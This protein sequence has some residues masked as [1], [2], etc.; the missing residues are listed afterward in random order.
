MDT[1][2]QDLRYAFRVLIKKPGFLAVAVIAL[3]LGIGANSAIFSV[4]NSVLL[5]SLPYKDADRLVFI[6][7][8]YPKLNLLQASVSAPSYV[9]YRDK[10]ESFEQV[11]AGTGWQ[12]NLTGITEPERLR[13][14]TVTANF[15]PAVGVEPIRGRVFS[16]EEDRPGNDKVVLISH[17]LWQRRFGGREDILNQT[18][19]LDDQSHTIIGILP[20]QFQ[21]WGGDVDAVKPIAFTPEQVA[22]TNGVEYLVVIAKLKQG[23]SFEQA[24]TEM[25]TVADRLRA[26]FYGEG[27]S[28][29][30][31]TNPLPEELLGDYRLML[32]IPFGF[33]GCVLLI[34]CANVANLMLARATSRQREIAIRTALGA[35]RRRVVRQL[36]TESVLLSLFGGALGIA[37]AFVAI[38]LLV[39]GIPAEVAERLIG[40]KQVGLNAEVLVFTIGVSLLTGIV[41]GIVPAIQASRPDLNESLKEGGRSGSEGGHRNRIRSALVVF[42]VAIALVLLVGAGLLI[43]SFIKLQEVSPGFN[44]EGVLTMQM[45]LPRSKYNKPEEM[46]AFYDRALEKISAT[47][48]VEHAAFGTNLPMSNNNSSASFTIEGLQVPQGEANPHGDNH[49]VTSDY[50]NTMQIPLIEGRYFTEQDTKDSL[51]VAIIDKV[52]ADKYFPG[53]SAVGKRMAVFFESQDNN[54][55]W[56]EIVGVV[57]NVKRYGLDGKIKEQYYFPQGQR[58]ARGVYLLV[59]SSTSSPTQLAGPVKEAIRSID[60]DQP[61]F[62]VMTMEQVVSNFVATKRFLMLLV[63]VFAGLALLLAAVGL[64]GVMSYSVT[65]RTHEIGIRMALGASSRDVRGMVVRQGM[66]LTL[67]G[68][69]IG[70]AGA[71]AVTALLSSFFSQLLFGIPATDPVTFAVLSVLLLGIAFLASYIPARRATRV[72]PMI[73][74]RY[75]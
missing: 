51:P 9:E 55:Y 54:L 62:R 24:R 72:D 27:S 63:T 32:L 67:I 41:F 69:G 58:T 56:R 70:L 10:T 60:K 48:G 68:L 13:G 73:A 3:A 21:F 46:M 8:S 23:V 14:A 12:V 64:Y 15:F 25:N 66:I 34:A 1:F 75:E 29:G 44:P 28:W 7:H 36:M 5:H 16:A 43:R 40:W 49:S 2:I 18:I 65:Q 4:V 11:A 6:W 37:V 53:Q 26:E 33:V 45:S 61:V 52:I 17:G 74:L 42:E 30:I 47:A 19:T 38:K 39:M 35:T 50:F 59:R 22:P 71:I 31:V 20:P 57:G